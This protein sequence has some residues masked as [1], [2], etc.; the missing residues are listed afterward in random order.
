M[1]AEDRAVASGLGQRMREAVCFPS[2]NTALALQGGE[3]L[4]WVPAQHLVFLMGPAYRKVGS[5]AL[6][7]CFQI[8]SFPTFIRSI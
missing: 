8:H 7:L 1:G 5:K 4:P 3:Q 6:Q 2:I